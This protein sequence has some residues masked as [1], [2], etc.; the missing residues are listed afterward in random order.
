LYILEGVKQTSVNTIL[1][2]DQVRILLVEYKHRIRSSF[3]FY[4]QDLLNNLFFHPYTKIEFPENNLKIT[5]QTASKYLD[6]LS[7]A[8]FLKKH[9]L[10]R[11]NYYINERLFNIFNK[12]GKE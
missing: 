12:A 1:I 3:N 8:G 4:S 10:G 5:R 9:K 6:K 2:I 11:A 7:K